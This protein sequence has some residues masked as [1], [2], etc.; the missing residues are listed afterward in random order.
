MYTC[1]I[2]NPW[3]IASSQSFDY[4][5]IIH[6]YYEVIRA[7]LITWSHY[8][9]MSCKISLYVCVLFFAKLYNTNKNSLLCPNTLNTWCHLGLPILPWSSRKIRKKYSPNCHPSITQVSPTYKIHS[10]K[11]FTSN[12]CRGCVADPRTA[13]LG[14]WVWNR[15]FLIITWQY[16]FYR[17]ALLTKTSFHCHT[18]K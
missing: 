13:N 2:Y 17:M 12:Y 18:A 1:T 8:T 4:W 5:Y 6:T 3:H 16:Q 10:R 7:V 9:I 15:Q 11:F 14:L